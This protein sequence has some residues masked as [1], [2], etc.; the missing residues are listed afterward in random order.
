MPRSAVRGAWRLDKQIRSKPV[1]ARQAPRQSTSAAAAH[2]RGYC[3]HMT[4]GE[5]VCGPRE[6]P[7][8]VTGPRTPRIP[9]PN[10]QL[11]TAA[12]TGTQRRV[13]SARISSHTP[14]IAHTEAWSRRHSRGAAR[15]G[16]CGLAP[17]NFGRPPTH[18]A[19]G[20][21]LVQTLRGPAGVVTGGRGL[22][23]GVSRPVSGKR[24]GYARATAPYAHRS[25]L[26]QRMEQAKVVRRLHCCLQDLQLSSH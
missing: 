24:G 17:C 14:G 12:A 16:V 7:G 3:E 8:G 11:V 9:P 6:R 25:D 22:C 1:R 21:S 20:S 26:F 2:T 10:T 18:R 13:Q 19:A 23:D 4:P 15:G 5:R